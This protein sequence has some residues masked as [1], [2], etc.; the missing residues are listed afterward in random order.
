MNMSINTKTFQHY[1]T[2]QRVGHNASGVF[3]QIIVYI[4]ALYK[5]FRHLSGRGVKRGGFFFRI[6][7]E[8]MMEKSQNSGKDRVKFIKDCCGVSNTYKCIHSLKYSLSTLQTCVFQERIQFYMAAS[9]NWQFLLLCVNIC[10][11][12]LSPIYFAQ[13]GGSE[14]NIPYSNRI[15]F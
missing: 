5:I 6:Y 11:I 7:A 1:Q 3:N 12:Y 13:K 2:N 9:K 10:I 4:S 14:V 15:L 8:Y